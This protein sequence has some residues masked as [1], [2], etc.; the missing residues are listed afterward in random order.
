MYIS[1]ME[2]ME[3]DGEWTCKLYKNREDIIYGP[4]ITVWFLNKDNKITVQYKG[5]EIFSRDMDAT[6][7]D[8]FDIHILPPTLVVEDLKQIKEACDKFWVKKGR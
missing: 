7:N 8:G 4:Y 2:L 5:E 3:D 1:L 6:W